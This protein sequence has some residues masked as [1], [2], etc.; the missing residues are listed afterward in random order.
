MSFSSDERLR[1]LHRGRDPIT[2]EVALSRIAALTEIDP[3]PHQLSHAHSA[4]RSSPTTASTA[5]S[6][7]FPSIDSGAPSNPTSV[8][9]ISPVN[10]QRAPET[11]CTPRPTR[12]TPPVR[13]GSFN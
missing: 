3:P 2:S 13:T 5:I 1:E 4:A 6:N 11:E 9:L 12:T 10:R 7:G 8:T